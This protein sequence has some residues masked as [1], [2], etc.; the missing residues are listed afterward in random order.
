MPAQRDRTVG[1][2]GETADA[3]ARQLSAN[4]RLA[5]NGNGTNGHNGHNGNGG[6]T[7]QSLAVE[8]GAALLGQAGAGT[9]E[10]SDDV[11]L[12][13]EAIG[14]RVGI[15][16]EDAE[17]LLAAAQLHDIGKACVPKR[18]L[19]KR[20][21]LTDEEWELMRQ[22]TL[23]GQRILSSVAELEEVGRLVRHSHERWD[24]GG[25]PD[26]LAG[27]EIPLGSRIIFCADAFHAIRSDRPYRPGRS[28]D[29]ALA[30]IKRCAGS[31]FDPDVVRDLEA[32]VRE[33][34]RKPRA[35]GRSARLFALLACLVIA[36]AG[37]A[38]ARSGLLG[39]SSAPSS[40][41]APK[42]PPACG[43]AACP[44]VAGPVGG[45][46]AVGSKQGARALHPGLPGQLHRHGSAA[47]E[48]A[49]NGTGNTGDS[50]QGNGSES[51]STS[52]G[53]GGR[54]SHKGGSSSSAPGHTG[55]SNGH[56]SGTG[57]SGGSHSSGGGAGNSSHGS[58]GSQGNA[59]GSQ[60]SAG[61]QGN[62][63]GPQGNAGVSDD[64]APGN[65]GNASG[66]NK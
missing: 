60:G 18:I 58:A 35:T 7:A 47:T 24:G 27:A 10:H 38:I 63:A 16:G 29:E 57:N 64:S 13:T 19:E 46:S 62:A 5:A 4:L 3:L 25:Y 48:G 41:S 52:H 66:H 12:I 22:H 17:T 53:N 21:Q 32:V 61:S 39:G 56:H 1:P 2:G 44:S 51:S 14:E 49:G 43:T 15:A 23:V 33:R 42:P 8:V 28:A 37:S 59:G 6:V 50:T 40:S 45:L 34:R 55:R 11:V 36:G 65:L 20:G 54:A 9:A 30:E 26:G 31:Q